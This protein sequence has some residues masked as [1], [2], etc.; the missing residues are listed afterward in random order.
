MDLKILAAVFTT[1][2]AVFVAMNAGGLSAPENGTGL[3][4]LLPGFLSPEPAQ[5]QTPVSANI[6]VL[7]DNTTLNVNGNVTIDGLTQY[8]SDDVDIQSNSDIEFKNF[9]GNLMIGNKS[10]ISGSAEGFTSNGVQVARNF[11]LEKQLNTSLIQIKGAERVGLRFERADID[12][13]ATNSSSGITETN[14]SVNIESF[15]GNITVMPEQMSISLDGNIST[16]EAGQTT[17]GGN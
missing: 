10:R 7:T 2:A 6:K 14:T 15:T 4:G 3:Q 11:Q 5:P 8:L 1:L 9:E 12:L 13:E 17:F 16:V